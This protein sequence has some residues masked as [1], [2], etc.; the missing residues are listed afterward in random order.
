MLGVFFTTASTVYFLVYF[1]CLCTV[2]MS[3]LHCGDIAS[4]LWRRCLCTAETL[5]L[6][7]GGEVV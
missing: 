3:S 4:A 7:C 2:M 6:H 1:C 5:P